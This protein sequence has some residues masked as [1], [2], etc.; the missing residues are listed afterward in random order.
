MTPGAFI[1]LM[2]FHEYWLPPVVAAGYFFLR[3]KAVST[4]LGYFL[5]SF[6]IAFVALKLLPFVLALSAVVQGKGHSSGFLQYWP[7]IQLALAVPICIASAWFSAR[8]FAT[9]PVSPPEN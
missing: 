2:L 8:L 6:A 3:K 7:F 5:T 1:L 9:P 4:R